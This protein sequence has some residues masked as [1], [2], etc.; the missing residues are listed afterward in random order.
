[1][2][3]ELRLGRR[4]GGSEIDAII[5][6]QNG[7]LAS[8]QLDAILESTD[9]GVGDVLVGDVDLN[10]AVEFADIQA[11]LDILEAGTFKAEADSNQDGSVTFDDIDRLTE[12]LKAQ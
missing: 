4:E 5:F 6:H 2:P 1:M 11:F 8:V 7:S 10:G 3:L 9:A 12:I